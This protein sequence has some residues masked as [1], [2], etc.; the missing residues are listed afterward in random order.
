M[1][2][3]YER[4]VAAIGGRAG[5]FVLQVS[6][7]YRGGTATADC[8]VVPDSGSGELRGLRGEARYVAT[9]ADY[10]N[11]PFTLDYSFE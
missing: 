7:T 6:G 1:F 5:S 8:S 2:A 4:V 3:G 11:V 9:H 10:P